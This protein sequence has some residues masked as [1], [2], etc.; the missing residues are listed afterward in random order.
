M[1]K[2]QINLVK[3]DYEKG[4]YKHWILCL[5][6]V[7]S[8]GNPFTHRTE[9]QYDLISFMSLGTCTNQNSVTNCELFNLVSL[10]NFVC[11]SLPPVEKFPEENPSLPQPSSSTPRPRVP[12]WHSG[13]LPPG[14]CSSSTS[15]SE[16]PSAQKP[17]AG[18]S[19]ESHS[20]LRGTRTYSRIS[21]TLDSKPLFC[22]MSLNCR[23]PLNIYY[24][25]TLP[26]IVCCMFIVFVLFILFWENYHMGVIIHQ[27]RS[28]WLSISCCCSLNA[29]FVF[30]SIEKECDLNKHCRVLDPERKKLCSRE[31]ICN[32]NSQCYQCLH[33][34]SF[35]TTRWVFLSLRLHLL[36][37]EDLYQFFWTWCNA[38]FSSA[39]LFSLHR[40]TPSTSSR[41][42][43][44][45]LRALISWQRRR[46][47]PQQ[48]E[49]WSSF[50]SN[51][52][53]RSNI[54]KLL[55][56]RQQL[57]AANITPAATVTFSGMMILKLFDFVYIYRIVNNYLL[58]PLRT[59]LFIQFI[60]S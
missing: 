16:R 30:F 4:L 21:K 14:H 44:G 39:V 7:N 40:L 43:W 57:R 15:P 24:F 1:N 38:F 37:V 51:Q 45:R 50:S 55:K 18:Q 53:T 35:L 60:K 49:I 28:C 46:E 8:P 19:S 36:F 29:V 2:S 20:P 52:K 42:R 5:I 58:C 9:K 31:L 11:C 12:P 3:N 33:C 17:T 10:S 32:V 48:V 41:R 23:N 56:R 34:C 54:W 25:V 27:H 6:P 22:H 13:P 26:F 47:Q 59:C